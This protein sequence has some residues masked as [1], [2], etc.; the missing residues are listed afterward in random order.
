ML[1]QNEFLPP[2]LSLENPGREN[3]YMNEQKAYELKYKP[4]F[5]SAP[6]LIYLHKGVLINEIL[7]H[8]KSATQPSNHRKLIMYSAV[9]ILSPFNICSS[10][11]A[12][13]GGAS[14][15]SSSFLYQMFKNFLVKYIIPGL[16]EFT[17]QSLIAQLV[18]N[19]HAMQV[20]PVW[21]LGQED[22]LEK[23]LATHSSILGLLLW[24][25]W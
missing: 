24:L 10:V 20:T 12:L 5:S 25:S 21:F 4:T 15:S 8:M 19:P 7:N 1:H 11:W 3:L 18:K 6:L 22:P 16:K 13:S 17:I 9:S 2:F 14:T 23:G